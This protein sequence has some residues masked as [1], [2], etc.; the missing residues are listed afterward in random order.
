MRYLLDLKEM[1]YGEFIDTKSLQELNDINI[2][3]RLSVLKSNLNSFTKDEFKL[4]ENMLSIMTEISCIKNA[5]EMKVT[6]NTIIDKRYKEK[7]YL[8]S[9]GAVTTSKKNRVWANH[10]H[11][12]ES[13]FVNGRKNEKVI[14]DGRN[15]VINK[16][17]SELKIINGL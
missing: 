12:P 16:I 2:N 17:I 9:R 13:K 7:I 11:G 3:N 14:K 10:Y 15:I 8:Q 1:K 6:M 5:I 4:F